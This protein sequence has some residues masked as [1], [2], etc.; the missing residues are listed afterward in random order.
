[1]SNS[2]SHFAVNSVTCS[3]KSDKYC[4]TVTTVCTV[5][6]IMHFVQLHI[7]LESVT[8]CRRVSYI[9]M[10]TQSYIAYGQTHI[11]VLSFTNCCT[12]TFCFTVSLILHYRP[13]H[14]AVSLK[15]RKLKSVKNCCAEGYILKT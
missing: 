4:S 14:V 12:F 11:A 1:M 15:H 8:Y 13:S 7:D 5:S 3:S 10:Y 9:Y 2:Q 6:Q